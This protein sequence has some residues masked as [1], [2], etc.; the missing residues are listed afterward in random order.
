TLKEEKD[1][2]IEMIDKDI[3][4]HAKL[5]QHEERILMH[6]F[7]TQAVADNS[8]CIPFDQMEK[9]I[10]DNASLV[11]VELTLGGAVKGRVIVRLDKNLPNIRENI[12]K[13]FS[14]RIGPSLSGRELDNYTESFGMSNLPFSQIPVTPDSN[15]RTIAKQGDVTGYFKAGYL[16]VI[17]FTTAAPPKTYDFTPGWCVFGN[18]EEGLD[19]LLECHTNRKRD[20]IIS[21]CGL[22]I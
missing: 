8:I 10:P 22:V 12:V 7:S 2:Y 5:S 19:I 9:M 13:I 4:K 15:G 21:D 18:V 6:S 14:G 11:F 20:V 16:Q 3:K 1:A 17:S